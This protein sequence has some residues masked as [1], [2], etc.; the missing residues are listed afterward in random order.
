MQTH[1]DRLAASRSTR[2]R[3]A[4]PAL[5][6]PRLRS[7]LALAAPHDAAARERNAQTLQ[8]VLG[9]AAP[10]PAAEVAQAMA[11]EPP[12]RK[13][14]G[15]DMLF[16]GLQQPATL[17]HGATRF[18]GLGASG[19]SRPVGAPT[20]DQGWLSK[21][22][23]R[24]KGGGKASAP[25]PVAA[26]KLTTAGGSEARPELETI[27][28]T[29]VV[30]AAIENDWTASKPNAPGEKN[31]RGFWVLRAGDGTLSVQAFPSNGT[32]DSLTPGPMPSGAV[33]FFHTH[34]NTSAEGY[35]QEPSDADKNFATAKGIPG[36][37][38]SHDGMYYFG[39]ALP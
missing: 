20:L 23:D 27:A 16:A 38:M 19:G 18:A 3:A 36:L 1:A 6:G 28:D 34:P 26:K 29:P 25:K 7:A 9:G 13:A 37:V 8:R 21:L 39:P 24:F 12:G 10:A 2:L 33:A 31:E 35:L 22:I 11:N 15:N 17:A 30:Q 5:L 32:K 4:A 14:V